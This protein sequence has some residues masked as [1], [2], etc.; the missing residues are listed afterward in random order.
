MINPSELLFVR[1]EASNSLRSALEKL[2]CLS[3]ASA[4][5]GDEHC[6]VSALRIQIWIAQLHAERNK[7]SQ[8]S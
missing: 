4:L 5:T 3:G 8:A 2:L 6:E 7:G 1:V